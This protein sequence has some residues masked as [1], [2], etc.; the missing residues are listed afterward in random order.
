MAARAKYQI[1][2]LYDD[3]R[4]QGLL[5]YRPSSSDVI[6]C[7]YLVRIWRT[8]MYVHKCEVKAQLH[9]YGDGKFMA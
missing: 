2:A 3:V 4:A 7:Q 9:G 6:R 5:V 1:L 8:S